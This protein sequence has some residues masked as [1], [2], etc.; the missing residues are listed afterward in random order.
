MYRNKAFS[1]KVVYAP[2]T[3]RVI[4]LKLSA[5]ASEWNRISNYLGQASTQTPFEFYDVLVDALKEA[6]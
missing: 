5:P 3:E 6:E 1:A 4:T 2:P